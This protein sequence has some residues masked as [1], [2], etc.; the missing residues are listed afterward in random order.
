MRFT[1]KI[2]LLEKPPQSV[3]DKFL[4]FLKREKSQR[5]EE[6][7]E[8][9]DEEWMHPVEI[10]LVSA[11]LRR[12]RLNYLRFRMRVVGNATLFINLLRRNII[13]S[14]DAK[15]RAYS[16]KLRKEHADQVNKVK[17]GRGGG[18]WTIWLQIISICL[19]FTMYTT[20]AIMLFPDLNESLF[21]L[22]WINEVAWIIEIIRRLIFN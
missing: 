11:A 4:S 8:G 21:K 3:K 18:I 19:W 22:L 5:P 13:K 17:Y 15:M 12:E 9:F 7:S 14:D 2:S 1:D 10:H 20:P 16:L 6:E